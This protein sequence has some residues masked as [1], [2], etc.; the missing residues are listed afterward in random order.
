MCQNYIVILTESQKAALL[1][2]CLVCKS[3]EPS[4]TKIN[5]WKKRLIK[6]YTTRPPVKMNTCDPRLE[7]IIFQTDILEP[8]RTEE[9]VSKRTFTELRRGMKWI[10]HCRIWDCA[11]KRNKS[12]GDRLAAGITSICVQDKKLFGE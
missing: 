12:Q 10:P 4:L 2:K 3:P 5:Q 1:N 9:R 6:L 7:T 8:T 11:E